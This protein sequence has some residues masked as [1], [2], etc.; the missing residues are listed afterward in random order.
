[1]FQFHILVTCELIMHAAMACRPLT[2]NYTTIFLMIYLLK[3]RTLLMLNLCYFMIMMLECLKSTK[4]NV[5]SKMSIKKCL[6]NINQFS[7]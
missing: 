2:K 6:E 7:Y 3:R 5:L 1:M 4:K